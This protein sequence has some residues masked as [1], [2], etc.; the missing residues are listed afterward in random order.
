[1]TSTFHG[2]ETARRGMMTQQSALHTTGHN[3]ANANT[4]GYTRQRVNFG[5]TEPYPNAARNAPRMPG[6]IGTGVEADFIQRIRENYLDIQYRGEQAQ[7]NYWETR[8]GEL[9]RIE[10]LMKEPSNE[11]IANMMDEFWESLQDLSV[12]PEDSG[13]RSVVR[14]RGI[15]LT[16]TFNYV[17]DSL[18]ANKQ[19]VQRELNTTKDQF[20]SLTKRIHDINGQIARTEPHGQMP[21]DLYD[22]RDRL[23]DELAGLVNID[24]KRNESKGNAEAAAEGTV[25]I[26]LADEEGKRL[27]TLVDG[28]NSD[29]KTLE[30]SEGASAEENG[31][32]EQHAYISEAVLDWDDDRGNDEEKNLDLD[33]GEE[34]S[35]IVFQDSPGKLKALVEAYG[36][37]EGSSMKGTYPEMIDN[38]D[39]MVK[40]FADRFNAV[41]K[42]GWNLNDVAAGEKGDGIA[43]FAFDGTEGSKGYASALMVSSDMKGD[44]D[45]IAAASNTEAMMTVT[46]GNEKQPGPLL[47]GTYTGD[48]DELYIQYNKDGGWQYS[49]QNPEDSENWTDLPE[50][51]TVD[52]TEL[53]IHTGGLQPEDGT[54]WNHDLSDSTGTQAYAGDGSN[55][56]N[57]SHVKDELLGFDG[58]TTDVQSFYQGVVGEMAV[59]TSEAQQQMNNTDQL[60][61][62]VDQRRQEVSSVSLDEEMTNMIQ[63]Q[64]AYNAA[65]RNITM[66]DEMLDRI[67]NNMGVVGR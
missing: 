53:A 39:T 15:A 50:E 67:I 45:N 59:H 41:H 25:D 47:T 6:Q 27:T 48:K 43:F 60:R 56:L 23:I 52:E 1:M 54:V 62:T 18:Q 31:E 19:D 40:T 46:E 38:L 34:L 61:A 42:S 57:L 51:G 3:I 11:G 8:H 10:D 2:L 7:A 14:Q 49:F 22:E 55:A 5:Q 63:F 4:D 26:Y 58:S 12:N 65:A 66:I 16:E 21:N 29:F 37:R 35:D 36:Y 13:A 44:L 9:E 30:I 24:V 33:D 28:E 20:N 64:H 17:S 32:K